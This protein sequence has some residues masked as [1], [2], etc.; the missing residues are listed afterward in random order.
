MD[1]PSDGVAPDRKRTKTPRKSVARVAPKPVARSAAPADSLATA[2]AT[3]SAPLIVGIGASAG[4]LNAFKGFF[5]AMPADSGMAFVLVQHLDPNHKSILAELIGRQ[6]T[7]TVLDAQHGAVVAANCVY[8]IPPDTTL[9]IVGGALQIE[10]PAP[11]RQRRFPIDT[12]FSSLAE[13]QGDNAVCIVLAGTGSDGTIGLKMIKEHGGLAFAQS[14]ADDMAMSGMPQSAAATG[15]VDRIMPVED[16]PAQLIEYRQRLLD[17]AGPHGR[18]GGSQD[19]ADQLATITALLR[20]GSG[21]DFA[22][23]KAST[24]V[25]RI[26]RRM[27]VL[28][29]DNAPLRLILE[30]A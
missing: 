2:T 16:M 3:S 29:I 24:L 4:G 25:R 20:V 8:I 23:Y 21:H 11:P 6:T 12:F 9:T 7:M 15:L 1:N 22:R 28:R 13:D 10:Q 26:Q 17:Q 14:E 27:Q 30:D 18:Q 19:T 5:A